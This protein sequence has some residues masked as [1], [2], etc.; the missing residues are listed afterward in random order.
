MNKYLKTCLTRFTCPNCKNDY[1]NY[2]NDI[3]IKID[4]DTEVTSSNM[5]L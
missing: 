4:R 1:N 2:M 5:Y 3:A